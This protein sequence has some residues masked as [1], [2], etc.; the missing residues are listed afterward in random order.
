MDGAASSNSDEEMAAMI[1]EARVTTDP[2]AR[3]ELYDAIFQR[4]HDMH[5]TVPLFN[6]QDIYG[7][8]PRMEWKPR[9]DAKMLIKEMSV[10]E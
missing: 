8:S 7:M 5:Y 10:S 6:L 1:D 2:E 9:V 4:G 3:Q